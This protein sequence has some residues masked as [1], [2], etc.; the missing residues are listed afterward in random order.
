MGRL[1]MAFYLRHAGLN[2]SIKRDATGHLVEANQFP[3]VGGVVVDRGDIAVEA[4]LDVRVTLAADC[5]GDT[6]PIAPDNRA[7]CA[8]ALDRGSPAQALLTGQ[9]PRGGSRVA[10]GATGS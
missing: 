7:G 10:V 5:A 8:Q 6:D 9:I 3:G 2:G 1:G 4:D